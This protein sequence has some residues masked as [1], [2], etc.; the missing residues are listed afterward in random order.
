MLKQRWGKADGSLSHPAL[1]SG[2]EL[3]RIPAGYLKDY[4]SYPTREWSDGLLRDAATRA[5]RNIV[6]EIL[7]GWV[8]GE[9]S[10][11]NPLASHGGA[12]I[13]Y[14]GSG[15]EGTGRDLGHA[16]SV[17]FEDAGHFGNATDPYEKYEAVAV[18]QYKNAAGINLT[19]LI[20]DA[21]GESYNS[22]VA[23][24]QRRGES[25]IDQCIKVSQIPENQYY[26][27]C[28]HFGL[29]TTDTIPANAVGNTE[30]DFSDGTEAFLAP[31]ETAG[32][33]PGSD[34]QETKTADVE[35][36]GT[37][38]ETVETDNPEDVTE[39]PIEE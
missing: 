25:Y 29:P 8:E 20:V 22:I 23:D 1:L 16:A 38:G 18:V 6:C 37:A 30:D 34:E 14:G 17:F 11:V 7:G 15:W 19:S 2:I 5:S 39:V 12:F 24:Y 28:N 4:P 33:T 35:E 36:V 9:K 3:P 21:S 32:E 26:D 31:V 27:F 10:S 13:G